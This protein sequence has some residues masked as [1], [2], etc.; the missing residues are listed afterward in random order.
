[1][2]SNEVLDFSGFL[3]LIFKVVPFMLISLPKM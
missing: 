3:E 1:M 2:I